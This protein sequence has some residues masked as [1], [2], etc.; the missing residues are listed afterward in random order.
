M[1][2]ISPGK[3]EQTLYYGGDIITM[4]GDQP[5]YVE[6]VMERNGKIIYA[7]PKASAVNNFA[8]KTIKVDLKG[9]TLLP[10]FIEPHAHPVGIGAIILANDIV[11][12]HAWRMPQK[13]YPGVT[14]KDNYLKAVK[15]IID[16]KQ[17]KSKTV[18][19][20][21]YHKSWHGD[22]TLKD[23]NKVTGDVP[24]IIWQRSTHEIYLNSAAAKKYDVRKGILSKEDEEQADWDNLHFWERAYQVVKGN[25]LISFFGDREM[26]KRG[27]DRMSTMMLQNGLTAMMEPGFPTGSFEDEY[28]VLQYG[29]EKARSYTV[30]LMSGFPEQF[31]KKMGNDAYKKHIEELPGKYNTDYIK[32]LPNQYK[33]FADGAIYSL[34]LELREPFYNCS[35]C[36]AEWIIPP[37]EGEA[38]FN[39]WWDQGYKIHI[40]ITGDKAFETYLD[41]VKRAMKRHPR[42]D[43]RTTFHHVG[44]FDASQAQRAADL[45]VEISANPYYLWALAEKYS[46]TGLGKERAEN[47][48]ALKEFTQRNIPVSLH[49]DFAMAPAEPLMLAWVAATRTVDS[50]RV[51]KPE[52]RISVYDAIKGITITAAHT[53]EMEQQ[54]GSIKVGKDATFTLL[55]KNPF[56]IDPLEIKDIPVYGI[57]YK[58]KMIINKGKLAGADKDANGCIGSAG[59]RWCAK[60]GQCERPW[61]LAKKEKFDNT[62]EAFDQFCN[63]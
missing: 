50:G 21:G 5:T 14:G 52:E 42:K 13:T 38:I 54:I 24:T 33:T 10:G 19:I 27:I 6:A 26:L 44:L 58:G 18:L 61:E 36:K 37:K 57:V 56:K 62:R 63:N 25:K 7:G 39:Y 29:T 12:P 60:T 3:L 23:L 53:F 20:W 51:V 32:F 1:K 43:H 15:A 35:N 28:S 49:S 11:A 9:K 40:H 55:E 31:V 2:E 8:G 4:E 46:E 48:V 41:I 16:A 34:A 59:Y 45:G 47:M 22:L 17:D 30:Y